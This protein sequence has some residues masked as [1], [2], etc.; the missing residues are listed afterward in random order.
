MIYTVTLNPCLDRHLEVEELRPDDTNRVVSE[1]RYAAGKG[2]DVSVVLRELGEDSIALGFVGGWDGLEL[3][4]RLVNRGVQCDFTSTAGETRIN[5]HVFDRSHGT[6]TSI[7]VPGADVSPAELGAFCRR[8]RHLVPTPSYVAL[9]GS[10]PRGVTKNIYRQ[11]IP[12]LKEQGARV[13]LDADGEALSEG[14]KAGPFLIKPNVHEI[15]RLLGEDLR[16][17]SPEQ[18]HPRVRALLGGGLEVVIVSLGSRG[19]LAVDSEAAFHV[20]TPKVIVQSTIGSGDSAVAGMIHG[21]LH[22]QT[23]AEAACLAA[24]CG[25]ATA[26]TPGTELCRRADVEQLLEGTEARRL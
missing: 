26:M 10:V 9:C 23:L 2:I 5:I 7:S 17:A 16:E 22:N 11:V 8:V 18:I 1:T 24:A 13:V 19:L 20:T 4:G 21:L 6:R 12:W 14:I 15:S 3:E 25:A